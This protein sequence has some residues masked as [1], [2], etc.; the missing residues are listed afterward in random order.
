LRKNWGQALQV[1]IFCFLAFYEVMLMSRV[2]FNSTTLKNSH[3]MLHKKILVEK[4]KQVK[5]KYILFRLNNH[6]ILNSLAFAK[7][8]SFYRGIYKK[9]AFYHSYG[10]Y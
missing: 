2:F 9:E 3:E 1:H 5:V 7:E 8:F 10:I 6:T 4:K